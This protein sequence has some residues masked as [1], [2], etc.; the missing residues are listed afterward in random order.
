MRCPHC[1][2]NDLKIEISFSGPIAC[3]FN[4]EN[5]VEFELM[6]HVS[7]D[8]H[9][10]DESQCECLNCNWIGAVRDA[11]S[12]PAGEL[13]A[14]ATAS[15]SGGALGWMTVEDQQELKHLLVTEE[16]SPALRKHVEKL[17]H[18]VER[19]CSVLETMLRLQKKLSASDDDTIVG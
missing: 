1:S 9:W 15:V 10:N 8:S 14:D 17:M 13:D 5:D 16:C 19:L 11:N 2:G 18:E 12:S 6:D 3:K 4:D 7:L